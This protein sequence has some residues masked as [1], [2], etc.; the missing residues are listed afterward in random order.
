MSIVAVT[1]QRREFTMKVLGRMLEHLGVQ[2][3]KRRDTAIA[4]LVAN[5]WDA[6][7]HNV[8]VTVPAPHE[9]DA[10]ISTIVIR[11]DGDGMSP[12]Q[13][14][15]DYLVVGRNRRAQSDTY[16]GRP[17]MGRKGIG[18]L[19]G[20]GIASTMQVATWR[21]GQETEIALDI[22]ELKREAG[23]VGDI[24][25]AGV[26]RQTQGSDTPAGTR[27]TLSQLKQK[28]P[29]DISLLRESLAR[30]LSRTVRGELNIHVNSDIVG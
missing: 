7:A 19:A 26:V 3:Y 11:D 30:R 5:A 28:T 21:D 18:K 13:V 9:Y 25:I 1:E 29:L 10:A 15:D 23:Q 16:K 17:V 4:E 2:M 6:G 14:Q 8:W 22:R 12:D 24:P 27:V 20:F